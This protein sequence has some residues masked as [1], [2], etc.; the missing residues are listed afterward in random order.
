MSAPWLP[1]RIVLRLCI[2]VLLALI[3]AACGSSSSSTKNSTKPPARTKTS[4]SGVDLAALKAVAEKDASSSRIG[5]TQPIGK[6]IP[7]NKTLVYV[8][9]GAPACVLQGEAFAAAAKVLGWKVTTLN[10]EP[11]PESIQAAMNQVIRIHPDGVASAG[12]GASLYPEQ[13][14]EMLADHII[15]ESA[16]GAQASGQ[17]GISLDPIPPA[18]A[19]NAMS[20]LAEFAVYEAGG[21]G[22]TGS[23]LLTGYPIV[24]TYTAGY[25]NEMKKLC[26]NSK[27]AQ[28]DMDP[29]ALGTTGATQVVNFIRANPGMKSLFYS[30]DQ[31]G[32]G[33]VAAAKGAGVT[34]PKTYSWG[35]GGPG[36]QALQDGQREGAAVDPFNEVSWQ[37]VDGFARQFVG[38][39]VKPDEVFP[40]EHVVIW[41][42][43]LGNV[44]KTT[45][46]FP[47]VVPN[48]KAQFEA[49][50][51][52]K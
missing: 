24:K 50:W 40:T 52:I 34:V 43:A 25:T 18:V 16:T 49:L 14:K 45:N 3:V 48:Y 9:C 37:L 30:Y 26:P 32:D 15:V 21:C 29:T 19:A 41:S 11:T 8:N 13:L 10:A 17:D 6:P 51:G 36:I 31:M 22:F 5:P 47:A 7:K 27:Q 20:N 42:P 4:S 44:P 2:P 28:I 39:S 23:I 33:V 35:V 46:P 12:L 1:R 38:E